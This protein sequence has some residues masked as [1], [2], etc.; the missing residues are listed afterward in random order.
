[1]TPLDIRVA[2]TDATMAAFV[3]QT[4]VWGRYDC[5]RLAAHV[6]RGLGYRPRL[7]RGGRYSS[8]LGATKALRRTGF[9]SIDD[10][11]DGLGLARLPWS[12]A[13]AGD[14]V[15]LPGNAAMRALGVVIA[16][17]YVLAF[18]PHDNLCRVAAPSAA[19]VLTLWS[20]PPCRKPL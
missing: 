11:L 20:A 5:V 18:S 6:L 15:A 7:S 8:A 9:A 13:L 3:G 4:F 2:A 14:I 17:G 16:P 1:M 19:D 12:Y 10:A